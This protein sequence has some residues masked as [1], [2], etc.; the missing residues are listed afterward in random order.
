MNILIKDV[1]AL[2]PDGTTSKTNISVAKDRIV[3]IGDISDSFH[4][5]KVIDGNN[6]FAK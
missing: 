3:F 5:E 2:L 4:A 1:V 6:H